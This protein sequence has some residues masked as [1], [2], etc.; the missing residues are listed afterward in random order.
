MSPLMMPMRFSSFKCCETVAWESGNSSTKSPQTQ[1]FF[2]AK[3]RKIAT[4]AGCAN[5]L[6]KSAIRFSSSVKTSDFVVPIWCKN[7]N[8]SQYY[9]I[10]F[11]SK[12]LANKTFFTYLGKRSTL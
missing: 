4:L 8:S 12:N 6:A 9:D 1:A 7:A 2:S 10:N 11:N 5:A 3:S